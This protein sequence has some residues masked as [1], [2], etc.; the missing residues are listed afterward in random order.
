MCTR[1]SSVF[2]V[3]FISFCA[4]CTSYSYAQE[5]TP[6]QAVETEQ[7]QVQFNI[8]AQSL[9]QA[10]IQLAKQAD[11]NLN[12]SQSAQGKITGYDA[13]SINEAL[14][15]EQATQRLLGN[16]E[17]TYT[18]KNQTLSVDFVP[19]EKSEEESLAL[20]DVVIMGTREKDW[21]YSDPNT[22]TIISKE[23]LERLPPLHA[24]D[25]LAEA[26][27]VFVAED[28]SNSGIAVNIRG[29]QD[30]GRVNMSVDGARQN[31]QQTGHGVNGHAYVDPAL[32]RQI[33][34]EKGPTASVNGA[35]V[36]GGIVNFQTIN[37]SDVVGSKKKAGLMLNGTVGLGDLGNGYKYSGS[38]AG[39]FRIGGFD[40][41]AAL[42]QK[43]MGAY[44]GGTNWHYTSEE[45]EPERIRNMITSRTYQKLS[46]QFIKTGYDFS[47]TSRLE[48][49]YNRFAD[50]SNSKRGGEGK[51]NTTKITSDNYK[52]KYNYDEFNVAAK[53]TQTIND[54]HLKPDGMFS[55]FDVHYQTDTLGLSIDNA[56]HF[57]F[58]K[59]EFNLYYGAEYHLDRTL[60]EA[61]QVRYQLKDSDFTSSFSGTTPRGDRALASVFG[62]FE[63]NHDDY[64]ITSIGLRYDHYQLVGKTY[65]YLGTK[66]GKELRKD[67]GYCL[68]PRGQNNDICYNQ[69]PVW[70]PVLIE[71]DKGKLLPSF[72]MGVNIYEGVQP[73]ITYAK[74]WRPPAITESLMYGL[75]LANEGPPNAPNP[76]AKEE[77]SST[78]EAGLNLKFDG[79]F[80]NKDKFRAKFA[81]YEN[82]VENYIV[83]GSIFYPSLKGH[84]FAVDNKHYIGTV[85]FSNL[86][87]PLFYRGLEL[88]ADYE[89]NW[90][91]LK[92]S[93]S[94]TQLNYSS[95]YEP[96]VNDNN[97]RFS[98]KLKN[99]LNKQFV[100][101]VKPPKYKA[102][103][104]AELR[105]LDKRLRFGI[106][107]RYMSKNGLAGGPKN[108]LVVNE[109][110]IFDIYQ[111][112]QYKSL[113]TR[114]SVENVL[115]RLYA[116]PISLGGVNIGPG[117]TA[118]LTI[119]LKI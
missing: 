22:T 40:F 113:T 88:E 31:Y 60:P 105:Y 46:S 94:Q 41:L 20:D 6:S 15:L 106:R 39:A 13:S 62:R 63:W 34:I 64:L 103:L 116:T 84:G 91:Y 44:K 43:E 24:A 65:Y 117:T 27:G 42:S 79:V 58:K 26:P 67:V 70:G 32:I 55:S 95:E 68:T 3:F 107:G 52:L 81:G 38:A 98:Q 108:E 89:Y 37:A 75:H 21:I 47:A 2:R 25:M 78:W 51:T 115:D 54:S 93:F 61:Q 71:R 73:F 99:L 119:G 8:S 85:A 11:I 100:I 101:M 86:N 35:G 109:T 59:D 12:I 5:E 102:S 23:D 104:N 56:N 111:S 77:I 57:R 118:L 49:S 28:R 7:E 48:F 112:Y 10:L 30:F 29:M 74:G 66:R 4:L 45:D 50:D 80:T 53:F 14:S 87:Q 82:Q 114:F 92:A 1:F 33:Q 16:T 97:A 36:I 19:P 110:Y 9:S 69:L 90:L 76:F 17:F 72:S 96:L 18:L 83:L